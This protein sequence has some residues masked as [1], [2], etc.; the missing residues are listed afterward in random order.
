MSRWQ[1]KLARTPSIKSY[2]LSECFFFHDKLFLDSISL[3]ITVYSLLIIRKLQFPYY[4]IVK[5]SSIDN[6][7]E[8]LSLFSNISPASFVTMKAFFL[9]TPPHLPFSQHSIH[10]MYIYVHS[11]FLHFQTSI[12]LL[13]PWSLMWNF[14]KCCLECR[15]LLPT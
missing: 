10:F 11:I 3:D 2:N 4:C 9:W 7:V 5:Y 8:A 15:L 14:V 12:C 1:L 6:S 13:R